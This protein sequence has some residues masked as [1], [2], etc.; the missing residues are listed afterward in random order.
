ML[1]RCGTKADHYSSA[2]ELI[3]HRTFRTLSNHTVTMPELANRKV[4]KNC[5]NFLRPLS[6]LNLG[7]VIRFDVMIFS[8]DFRVSPVLPEEVRSEEEVK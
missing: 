6:F 8:A 7:E 2:N 5:R 1:V 4:P 3:N